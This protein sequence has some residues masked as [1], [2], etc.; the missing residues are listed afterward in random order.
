VLRHHAL[1]VRAPE[2]DSA[3]AF[4]AAKL[5]LAPERLAPSLTRLSAR[6]RHIYIEQV[7]PGPGP[8]ADQARA[9]AT[10]VVPDLDAVALTADEIDP[11]TRIPR[12]VRGGLCV[13]FRDP[14]GNV[15][16]LLEPHEGVAPTPWAG[17][18]IKIPIAS[19][20][21]ARR[22][23]GD[24]LC[25]AAQSERSYPP[26][27]FMV[28]RDGA[29][30]F[31]IE[32]KEIWEP[33]TRVRAPLYPRETGSVLVFTFSDL[34]ELHASLARR[35]IRMTQI[36]DFPLGRRMGVI[37]SAGLASEIWSL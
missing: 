22:L 5:D 19:V 18:G 3:V 27:I 37:D 32:D 15:H 4:Y 6:H 12:P 30:G 35:A 25:F 33:D 26:L 36:E 11:L 34:E 24:M 10:F 28:H 20:P 13:R 17:T 29:P 8:A 23:Y 31:T 1:L 16:A 7:A 9:F 14:F 2:M 21:A